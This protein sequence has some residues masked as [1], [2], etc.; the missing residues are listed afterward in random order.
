MAS[1]GSAPWR[2]VLLGKT[3]VGKSS[4]GNTI[5]GENVFKSE[6]RATSVTSTCSNKTR[7]INGQEITVIDTPGLYDTKMSNEDIIKETVKGVRMAAPGPHA[8]L[9]VIA[10]GRFTEEEKDTVR[11][12]QQVFGKGVHKHMIV[13]FTRGD[14][15]ENDDKTIEDYI[16]EAGPEM[17]ELI[18]ACGGRYHL[19]NNRKRDDN[20]QVKDLFSKIYNMLSLN[21]HTYYNYDLFTQTVAREKWERIIAELEAKLKE[22]QRNNKSRCTIL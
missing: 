4:V 8:F 16:E 12:F 3:G 14:D 7:E 20:T 21:K 22:I 18:S 1:F 9:L 5:L 6:S 17:R 11:N 15:L 19:L 10:V 13:L 2:L